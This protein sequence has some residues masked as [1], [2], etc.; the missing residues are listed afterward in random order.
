MQRNHNEMEGKYLKL[1]DRVA[2]LEANFFDI[3]RNQIHD[4]QRA[5][6]EEENSGAMDVNESSS[7]SNLVKRKV[8]ISNDD[9]LNV[10]DKRNKLNDVTISILFTFDINVHPNV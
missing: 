1:Q 4:I 5:N 8:D 9:N 10:E 3:L 7:D 2:T 6:I